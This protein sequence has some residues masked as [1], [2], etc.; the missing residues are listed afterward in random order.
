[1]TERELKNQS[2]MFRRGY[3]DGFNRDRTFFPVTG[4]ER[5][6]WAGWKEGQADYGRMFT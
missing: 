4:E 5:E 6:Y 2:E 3:W 1:M